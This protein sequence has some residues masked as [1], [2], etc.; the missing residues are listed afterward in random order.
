MQLNPERGR[1]HAQG[2]GEHVTSV[3]RRRGLRGE[4][5]KH[6][7]THAHAKRE[8]RKKFMSG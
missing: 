8:E 3:S 1:A 6:N 2:E 7:N 4:K 5:G